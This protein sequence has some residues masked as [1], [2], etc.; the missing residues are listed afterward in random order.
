MEGLFD[1]YIILNTAEIFNDSE[2]DSYYS[3]RTDSTDILRLLNNFNRPA[4][5]IC[6]NL[7]RYIGERTSADK[8]D[9]L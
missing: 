7:C 5:Y 4:G 1:R 8:A 3:R 6:K 9:C 2:T